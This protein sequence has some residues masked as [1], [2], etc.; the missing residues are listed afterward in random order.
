LQHHPTLFKPAKLLKRTTLN[1]YHSSNIV[2][3]LDKV[4]RVG[5]KWKNQGRGIAVCWM[6]SYVLLVKHC[7]FV[8]GGNTS[9][10]YR[11]FSM[12]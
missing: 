7:V 4:K 3:I 12:V 6:G 8:I 1:L 5:K 2:K 10:M 9:D 11:L